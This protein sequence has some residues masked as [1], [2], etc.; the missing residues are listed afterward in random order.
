VTGRNP[1]TSLPKG[2]HV[3]GTSSNA[4]CLFRSARLPRILRP[5]TLAFIGLAL[6]VALWGFGY[7]LS[8]YNPNPDVSTKASVAKLWDK[9][10]LLSAD[11][12][13]TV[14]VIP[15]Q[16]F[17]VSLLAALITLQ[18]TPRILEYCTPEQQSLPSGSFKALL[19][20]RSP[21][22]PSVWL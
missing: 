21:P 1:F 17:D 15:A 5:A 13:P 11:S 4:K 6:A 9:H 18:N 14:R 2:G 7:K 20:L 12:A 8:R 22:S 16:S 19:P 10:H 3:R